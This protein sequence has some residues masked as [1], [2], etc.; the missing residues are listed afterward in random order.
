MHIIVEDEPGELIIPEQKKKEKIDV[1]WED[2]IK[3]KSKNVKSDYELMQELGRGAFGTVSKVRM[4]NSNKLLRAMKSI[5]KSSL[6][7]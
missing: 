2:F 6:I 4:K 5:K 7:K 3:L 1:R